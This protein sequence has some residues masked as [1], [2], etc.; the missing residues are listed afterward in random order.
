MTKEKWALVVDDDEGWLERASAI[1]ASCGY[2]VVKAKSTR[3]AHWHLVGKAFDL[4]VTDN[5]MEHA[6]AGIELLMENWYNDADTPSIL[7]SSEL[8]D[9]QAARL[10]KDLPNVIFVQKRTGHDNPDLVAAI[11]KLRS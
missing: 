2:E 1:V 6:N 7:H 11:E 9:E 10:Q 8:S 3:E 4:L 5:F